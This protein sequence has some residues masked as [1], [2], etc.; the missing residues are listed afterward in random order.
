M[1]DLQATLQSILSD[2]EQ[3]ARISAIADSLG[4]KPPEAESAQ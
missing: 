3:M 4:L 1:E 2:P